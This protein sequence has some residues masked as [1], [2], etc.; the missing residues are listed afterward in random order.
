[1]IKLLE[2]ALKDAIKTNKCTLGSK[3]VLTSLKNSKLVVISK[4]V[5]QN[6]SEKIQSDAKKAKIPAIQFSDSSV[7]LGKLC[8]LQFRV[9]TVSFNSLSD[10]NIKSIMNEAEKK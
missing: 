3:Q 4:S 5:R 6:I 10:S 8:G 2:K 7:S 9:S 1:M